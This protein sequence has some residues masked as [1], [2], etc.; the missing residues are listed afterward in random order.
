MLGSAE[1]CAAGD[2]DQAYFIQA[3]SLVF[4]RILFLLVLLFHFTIEQPLAPRPLQCLDFLSVVPMSFPV[5][6]CIPVAEEQQQGLSMV[7]VL[8]PAFRETRAAAPAPS[9]SSKHPGHAWP[10]ALL[11]QR[12]TEHNSTFL[13]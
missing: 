6:V 9:A 2:Q 11:C 13:L 5:C 12:L 4:Y 3:T 8:T 1:V 10:G 7:C